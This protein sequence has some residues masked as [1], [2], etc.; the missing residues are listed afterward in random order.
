M[1]VNSAFCSINLRSTLVTPSRRQ[2]GAGRRA[3]HVQLVRQ[4]F[5]GSHSTTGWPLDPGLHGLWTLVSFA[6]ASPALGTERLQDLCKRSFVAVPC[7]FPLCCMFF[8]IGGDTQPL[9]VGANRGDKQR[10][11]R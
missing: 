3:R 4:H 9:A 11:M 2:V 7:G 10:E 5:Q 8:Y 6:P 1:E